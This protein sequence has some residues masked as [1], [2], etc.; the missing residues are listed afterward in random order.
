[1]IIMILE[2]FTMY[3][4]KGKGQSLVN[5]GDIV[6]MLGFWARFLDRG[7]T[8]QSKLALD[9]AGHKNTT[10]DVNMFGESM[11][12]SLGCNFK[13]EQLRNQPQVVHVCWLDV[14]NIWMSC[15]V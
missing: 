4:S 11:I 14:G 6:K 10:L 12:L 13:G 8:L 1:M 9:Q 7:K 5:Q 3:K 15:V 2:E